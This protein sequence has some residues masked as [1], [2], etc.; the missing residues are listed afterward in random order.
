MLKGSLDDFSL[1]D[2][3][4]LMSFAK[5]SGKLDIK[6]S[7]GEGH[8]FF[9]DGEVYYAESSLTKEPLGQKLIHNKALTEG[10]LRKALDESASSGKRVGRV[11]V[12]S[13]TVS[14]EAIES[15]VRQ[16]IEDA[17]FDLLRWELGEFDWLQ[18]EMLEVEVPI[19]VSVE[20][21]IMEA[22]RRLDELEVIQR[23]IPS[24]DVVMAMA[25]TPP[26]GAVEI[27]ITPEEWR[28]LVMVDGTRSVNDIAQMVGLDEFAAMR[29]LYG[30]V[31]AGLIEVAGAPSGYAPD[32]T[33]E[34]EA[35]LPE[36][37]VEPEPEV[38][39]EAEA[40]PDADVEA[41]AEAEP[42]AVVEAEVEPEVEPE[43]EPVA[44]EEAAP[45]EAEAEVE[46]A[47]EPEPMAAS[48]FAPDAEFDADAAFLD[49]FNVP[50]QG[51]EAEAAAETAPPAP[52][53][54]EVVAAAETAPD[55]AWMEGDLPVESF[56][57]P[58]GDELV[59]QMAGVE[60]NGEGTA[61]NFLNDLLAEPPTAPE[62][63]EVAAAPEAEAEP[64]EVIPVSAD[65]EGE[66]P[67][68]DRAAVVR[69]L[70]G[71]FDDDRPRPKAAPS[72]AEAGTTDDARKRVE[73]DDQVTRG[74]I[75][76]L[77]DGVKGL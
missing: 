60:P 13:G 10:Q 2:I 63:E 64:E 66:S 59:T 27:N 33:A 15:A 11:L 39:A 71:L 30:L 19:S 16:Q 4:R 49:E 46:V 73:D 50:S 21:L 55:E 62:A 42:E 29:M 40:E 24:G 28:L 56:D 58:T 52:P 22:S 77:I 17:A 8:V 32:E 31:S 75:S 65:P 18:D 25:A 37:D 14:E 47:A 70:A 54:P 9:R 6:R 34:A 7:A 48:E 53:E 76:R 67:R 36:V 61:D 3:F 51:G 41:E 74:I 72:R 1:P 26:D 12:E 38:G 57:Q 68:V 5:K 23:K 43:A 44:E 20:N 69:E 35:D 45:V